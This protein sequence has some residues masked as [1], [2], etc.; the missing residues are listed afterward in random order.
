MKKRVKQNHTP[1]AEGKIIPRVHLREVSSTDDEGPYEGIGADLRAAHVETGT[2]IAAIADNLRISKGYLEAIEDG[3]FRDLPGGA[4]V[5]GFLRSYA[6]YLDLE[7][8]SVIAR[9]KSE[10]E[11]PRSETKLAFPSPMDQGRL[12]TGR[13]LASSLVLAGL[14]YGGWYVVSGGQQQSADLVSPVPE[15]LAAIIDNSATSGVTGRAVSGVA[16]PIQDVEVAPAGPPEEALR[17]HA[18]VSAWKHWRA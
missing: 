17:R 4:Y 9:Y 8:E 10:S 18:W 5:Y 2:D 16:A 6:E 3:R 12:P 15:R 1:A 14:V 13:L 11:V 7:P